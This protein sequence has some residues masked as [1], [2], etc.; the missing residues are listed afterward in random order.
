MDHTTFVVARATVCPSKVFFFI[1]FIWP[2]DESQRLSDFV[3]SHPALRCTQLN[4]RERDSSGD[5]TVM[6]MMKRGEWDSI[7]RVH[8]LSP[9]LCSALL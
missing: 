4:E 5:V 1:F 8:L 9:L 2:L 3:P 6:L 7:E